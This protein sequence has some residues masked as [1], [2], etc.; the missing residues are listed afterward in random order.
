M[1]VDDDPDVVFIYK[2]ILERE[3]HEVIEI[4]NGYDCLKRI[5][6]EKPD[7]VTMDIM[8]PGLNGWEVC[9][10]I[11]ENEKTKHI[12]VVVVSIKSEAKDIEKSLKYAHAD[13][14]VGKFS[15][16]IEKVVMKYK[17]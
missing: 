2:R 11:K 8:M 7:L 6:D 15:E 3:G 9:K 10:K 16:D 12:P 13:A 4:Y 14:H 17:K 5:E 1:V